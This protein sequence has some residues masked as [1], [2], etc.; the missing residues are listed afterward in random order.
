MSLPEIQLFAPVVRGRKGTHAS[1]SS[2]PE[3]AVMCGCR[4]MEAFTSSSLDKNLKHNIEI[5]VD[6]LMVKPGIEKAPYGFH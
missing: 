4:L 1:F 5:V 6:C 3:G 2:M